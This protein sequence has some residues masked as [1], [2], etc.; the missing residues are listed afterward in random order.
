MNLI[1][2]KRDSYYKM[3]KIIYIFL[4]SIL[5]I[6]N[7]SCTN[8]SRRTHSF[9]FP[10]GTKHYKGD[11]E[12]LMLVIEDQQKNIFTNELKRRMGILIR[13]KNKNI[14]F[15]QE[16]PFK[17]KS[18]HSILELETVWEEFI[19]I[20]LKILE[21]GNDSIDKQNEKR[22]KKGEKLIVDDEYN[23]MLVREGPKLLFEFNYKYN[24]IIK[25]F[26]KQ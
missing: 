18:V 1:V 8:G 19:E 22:I 2:N 26:I 20:K 21:R 17:T 13:D 4:I 24:P 7:F 14:L 11:Y 12:Y 6:A 9:T 3:I 5:Q 15:K 25:K 16:F 10:K 23:K